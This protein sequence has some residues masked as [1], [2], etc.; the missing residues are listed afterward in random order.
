MRSNADDIYYRIGKI[1]IA[2]VFFYKAIEFFYCINGLDAEAPSYYATPGYLVVVLALVWLAAGISYLFNIARRLTAFIVTAFIVLI[3][4]T[5]TVRG[6]EHA[7]DV[8]TTLLKFA[9]WFSL[10]G[11]ALMLGSYGEEKYYDHNTREEIFTKPSSM[12]TI[13]R[14]LYGSFFMIAGIL[15]LTHVNTDATYVLQGMPGAQFW[16]IF[17]GICWILAAIAFWLNWINKLAALG[18]IILV[19][20]ITFMINLRGINSTNA[21]QDITQ[22]FTNITLI[23]G[24]LI[25]ASRGDWWFTKHEYAPDEES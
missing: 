16:V 1:L 8:V 18:V 4:T 13:G 11:C 10:M 20:I 19:I 15:H 9:G 2:L 12:F 21:W 23:A 17:T 7:Q 22:V 24:A 14:I 3:L 25:L 5:S 6:F